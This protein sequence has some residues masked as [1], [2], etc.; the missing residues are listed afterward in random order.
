MR[1]PKHASFPRR[2]S[3]AKVLSGGQKLLLGLVCIVTLIGALI[4]PHHTAIGL[5]A[6]A[7]IFWIVFVGF[8]MV[9]WEAGQ[10]YRYP[11]RHLVD[12]N[13]SHL[14]TYTIFLPLYKEARVVNKLAASIGSLQYPKNKLQVL[15]L[16]EQDDT[17]TLEAVLNAR[18]PKYFRIVKLLIPEPG[19]PQ[20]KPRALNA[21]LAIATGTCCVIYD[22]ED[23]PEPDQL[24]K[25]ASAFMHREDERVV[26]YQAR[27][28]FWNERTNWLTRFYW[29]E[30]I[31]HFE[32]VLAGL[33]KLALTPPLGGTSNH[34]LTSAVRE[35]GGWD[36]FNV[37]EDAEIA[38]A[39]ACRGYRIGMLDS[40]TYEEATAHICKADRQR[41]RWLKGYLQTGLVYTRSPLRTMRMMGA[42]NWF[43]F[44]LMMI[45]TVV[46]FLLNPFFWGATIVYFA[47]RTT[48]IEQLFPLPLYYTGVLLMIAGN[49]SLFYQLVIAC[50]KRE[51]FSSVK[52]TVQL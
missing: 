41:R 17:E 10:S 11:N 23:R 31:A 16:L 34:F 47:T 27:L 51:G 14:P 7:M 42:R 15:L 8:K 35:V 32:W 13:D 28:R 26:C 30:Y 2:Q 40:T 19:E 12:F 33:S 1:H 3:A 20:T 5:I 24:L 21:G 45:G 48:V 43:S 37:T 50:L 9:L 4:D 38:A 18:L 49:L 39:L 36:K 52:G 46:S 29:A 6:F 25:A 44:N 22:A